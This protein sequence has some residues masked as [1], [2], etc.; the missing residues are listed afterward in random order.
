MLFYIDHIHHRR[1]PHSDEITQ[2]RNTTHSVVVV[3]A[4]NIYNDN[5]SITYK[6]KKRSIITFKNKI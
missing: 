5:I 2:H 6:Q 4:E 1:N 3:R